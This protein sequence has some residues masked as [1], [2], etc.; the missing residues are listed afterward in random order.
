MKSFSSLLHGIHVYTLGCIDYVP[1]ISIKQE[2]A[3]DLWDQQASA[4]CL[5]FHETP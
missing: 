4:L 3:T 5:I 1:P 2:G